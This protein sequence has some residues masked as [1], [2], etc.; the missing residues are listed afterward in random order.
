MSSEKQDHKILYVNNNKNILNVN[1]AALSE[2]FLRTQRFKHN[3]LEQTRDYNSA[4]IKQFRRPYSDSR[5]TEDSAH[6]FL[7]PDWVLYLQPNV[8][9]EWALLLTWMQIVVSEGRE[10][11][12]KTTQGTNTP[13]IQDHLPFFSWSLFHSTPRYCSPCIILLTVFW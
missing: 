9:E 5:Y 1:K 13:E 6:H 3:C 4:S 8:Q 10:S 12:P 11:H 2:N 7:S